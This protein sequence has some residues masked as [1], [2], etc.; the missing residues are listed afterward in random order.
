MIDVDTARDEDVRTVSASSHQATC[1]NIEGGT[2]LF[3][4]TLTECG[5]I[6]TSMHSLKCEM[7]DVIRLQAGNG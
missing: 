3:Y 5:L 1:G 4:M 2:R 6:R 7:Y